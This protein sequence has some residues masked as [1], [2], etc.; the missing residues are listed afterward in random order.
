MRR[1]S[2]APSLPTAPRPDARPLAGEGAAPGWGT[3]LDAAP[4][5]GLAR[6][7][8]IAK[9]GSILRPRPSTGAWRKGHHPTNGMSIAFCSPAVR[10]PLLYPRQ[11]ILPNRHRPRPRRGADGDW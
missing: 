9:P 1:R 4:R 8:L 7:D 10:G 6:P 5:S 2:I 3:L 11:I